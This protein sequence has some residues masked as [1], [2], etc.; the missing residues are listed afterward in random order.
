MT[1]TSPI[2]G[3]GLLDE[4]EAF[5]RRF[6]AFP[7]PA[8]YAAVTLW[9]AHTHLQDAFESTPRLA[10]LSPGPGSG[11][12]QG[13]AVCGTLVPQPMTA[14]DTSPAALFR[15]V[16]GQDGRRPTILF[17]EI[18]TLLGSQARGAEELLGLIIAGHR[19]T[20]VSYRSMRDGG[21]Q[22][23]Q[24]FPSYAAMAVASLGR[25]PEAILSRSV[26]IRMHRP[27]P[28]ERLEAFRARIHR[29]EG[30]ALRDRLAAWAH[31]VRARIDGARPGMPEGVSARSAD[32]WE[33]L[34]AV[35]DTAGGDWPRRAREACTALAP[36]PEHPSTR[37]HQTTVSTKEEKNAA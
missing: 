14:A 35:A 6:T 31:S 28:S 8:A 36:L 17:H 10:F 22:A 19:R 3:A 27:A 11:S 2:D 26:V 13:L 34:L 33:P 1:T 29:P 30:H 15:A 37:T 23:V 5:H 24:A 20:G 12:T 7:T 32:V 4:I 21:Q 18:D 16:S 9:S 25:L